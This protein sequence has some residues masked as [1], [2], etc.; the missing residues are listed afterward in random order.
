MNK[1]KIALLIVILTL[2][3]NCTPQLP[4]VTD[5]AT[6]QATNTV[7]PTIKPTKTVTPI[8]TATDLP[9]ISTNQVKAKVKELLETNGGCELP[10]WWGIKPGISQMEDVRAQLTTFSGIAKTMYVGQAGESW[11]LGYLE[12]NYPEG[13]EVIINIDSTYLAP[14]DGDEIIVIGV[15]TQAL[16][17]SLAG[18]IY[19][20]LKYS[21]LLSAYTL[22][23]ILFKYG[24]PAQVFFTADIYEYE[25]DAPDFFEIRLLYPDRG[26]FAIYKMPAETTANTYRFCPSNSFIKLTLIPQDLGDSYQELLLKLG[27]EWN[28]FFPL[29]PFHKTPEEAI[30]MSIED[31]YRIFSSSANECLESPSSIWPER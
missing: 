3:S 9:T 25:K 10:C 4:V 6:P 21:E 29:S 23:Q 20:D 19:G 15:D 2:L 24:I 18:L 16:P 1:T 26:I 30:G 14:S 27:D 28:G 17:Q 5:T 8:P 7:V 11:S 12:I 13:N 31:F 22:P